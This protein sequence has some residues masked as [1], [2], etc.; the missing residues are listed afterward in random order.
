MKKKGHRMKH[1]KDISILIVDDEVDIVDYIG[2]NFELDDFI[3][4]K[5]YSVDQALK[6]LQENKID[7]ILSDICMPKKTGMDLLEEIRINPA[8]VP[9]LLF[10]TGFSEITREQAIEKGALDILFKPIDV[11]K[12]IELVLENVS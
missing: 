9:K 10:M 12:V 7:F 2:A 5:A 6:I 3:V 1:P 4:Y 11:E 8:A